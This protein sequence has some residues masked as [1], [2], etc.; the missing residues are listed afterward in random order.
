MDS[1]N[2]QCAKEKNSKGLQNQELTQ[3][4]SKPPVDVLP[5]PHAVTP[6]PEAKIMPEPDKKVNLATLP[7]ESKI[8]TDLGSTVVSE[9]EAG[10]RLETPSENFT[11][12]GSEKKSLA[13]Q[14]ETRMPSEEDQKKSNSVANLPVAINIIKEEP[15]NAKTKI[16]EE[17]KAKITP[18]TSE[19]SFALA[20][21]PKAVLLLSPTPKSQKEKMTT[22]GESNGKKWMSEPRSIVN[23]KNRIV[24]EGDITPLKEMRISSTDAVLEDP[25]TE[26]KKL[27]Q[28][29]INE[30]IQIPKTK[31]IENQLEEYT[32]RTDMATK[33]DSENTVVIQT[34]IDISN[35]SKPDNRS[36]LSLNPKNMIVAEKENRC[37]FK[38]QLFVKSE[39]KTRSK[40][41]TSVG[42]EKER[43]NLMRL[44]GHTSK[45]LIKR[46]ISKS[47][48]DSKRFMKK[49][50]MP[51]SRRKKRVDM[52]N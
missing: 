38:S 43:M 5:P 1:K 23:A 35:L 47:K 34:Q 20:L 52:A 6:Q 17:T 30:T 28:A 8:T 46:K 4:I 36:T 7:A 45:D 32:K 29:E 16:T 51:R 15:T 18:E 44:R 48:S 40:I 2:L 27:T 42:P 41:R 10:K 39:S 9:H 50:R 14:I 26:S 13:S 3:E 37:R 22:N 21:K 19:N 24:E 49:R 12:L 31:Q 11:Q 33:C 25:I